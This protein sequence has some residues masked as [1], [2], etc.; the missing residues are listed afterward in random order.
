MSSSREQLVLSAV[1][2]TA[3]VSIIYL[4]PFVVVLGSVEP[5]ED[6]AAPLAERH[7][8]GD[9]RWGQM[10][11]L[12]KGWCGTPDAPQNQSACLTR[13]VNSCTR[14][15]TER[16]SRISRAIFDVAWMTVV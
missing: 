8:P 15:Y 2:A 12:H 5:G 3:S 16:S 4:K 14:L 7:V 13:A 9:A 1:P 6:A 10:D 11:P